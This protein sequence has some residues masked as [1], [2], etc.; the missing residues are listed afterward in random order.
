M[1]QR[2]REGRGNWATWCSACYQQAVRAIND[3][4]H[5]WITLIIFRYLNYFVSRPAFVLADYC[6]MGVAIFFLRDVFFYV[7]MRSE[8]FRQ[9]RCGLQGVMDIC[10]VAWRRRGG[11]DLKIQE[12]RNKH[13]IEIIFLNRT[14]I[15]HNQAS[16][17]KHRGKGRSGDTDKKS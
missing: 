15:F 10:Q 7:K 3:A 4:C 12:A 11:G 17:A 2:R 1:S 13:C 5:V 6:I 16:K 8:R 9:A 14:A